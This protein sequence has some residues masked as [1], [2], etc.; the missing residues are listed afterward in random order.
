MDNS[1]RPQYNQII[2][3]NTGLMQA[4]ASVNTSTSGGRI[5]FSHAFHK[6]KYSHGADYRITKKMEPATC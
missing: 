1:F 4:V 6:F 2:P 3:P 5:A